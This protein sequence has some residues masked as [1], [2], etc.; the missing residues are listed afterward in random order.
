MNKTIKRQIP[1]GIMMILCVGFIFYAFVPHQRTE[2]FY[3]WWLTWVRA[4]SP[5]GVVLGVIS[6]TRVH[7]AKISRKVPYWQYSVLALGGLVFTS[8]AGFYWG[9]EQGTPYMWMFLNVQMPLSATMFSLLAFYIASAAYKAF[10]ARS[11]EAT[12]LLIAAIIVMLAQVPIGMAISRRIPEIS[13]WILNVPNMAAKR[14]IFIG[15][16]LGGTAV[17]LKIM[18]GI[19]RTYLGSD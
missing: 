13:E 3:Q 5:F 17:S 1:M 18:L 4:I 10:R 15:V 14:G 9:T 7:W 2:D 16:G 12:V 19:E 6:F 11:A 8:F